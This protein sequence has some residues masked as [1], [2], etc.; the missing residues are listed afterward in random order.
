MSAID[1]AILGMII[2]QPRSAYELQKDVQYHQF[3][4]WSKIATPTIYQNVHRLEN[5]GYLQSEQLLGEK[6][7]ERP[8][9]SITDQGRGYFMQLM[10]QYVEQQI[11]F[12]FDFNIV[13]TNLDKISQTDAR[14]LLN[15]LQQN[16]INS[17]DMNKKTAVEYPDIPMVG[18]AIFQQQ[19]QLYKS[20]L[21]WLTQFIT[22]FEVE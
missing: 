8:V 12:L 20:L 21:V 16:I 19:Q 9:Y 5:K 7:V 13:I 6:G 22:D 2:E 4:R 10:T 14:L 15:K 17:A 1:L 3:S 11:A 18:L